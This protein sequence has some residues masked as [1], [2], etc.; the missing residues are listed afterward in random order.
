[1]AH[2]SAVIGERCVALRIPPP[3]LQTQVTAVCAHGTEANSDWTHP[4]S[5]NTS[6]NRNEAGSS[7]WHFYKAV[8]TAKENTCGVVLEK[9][10]KNLSFE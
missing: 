1:M 4:A 9:G 5:C 6:A 7:L 2:L 8:E 10:V 3:P